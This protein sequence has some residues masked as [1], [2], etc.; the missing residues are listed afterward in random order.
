MATE[1]KSSIVMD[2]AQII[3]KSNIIVLA[4]Y[5]GVSTPQL[6]ALRRRLKGVNSEIKIVK[7][8]LARLAAKNSGKEELAK[9]LVGPTAITFGYGDV[10]APVKTLVSYQM[11]AEGFT[12]KGGLL[13]NKMYNKEQIVTLATLPSREVLLGHILGQM[14]AP[15]SMFIGAL[16]SP[17]RG[18]IGILQA[19]INQMEAK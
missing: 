3:V 18:F 2:L 17:M 10:T 15:I 11:E 6:T 12:I 13:G 8:T 9:S 14:N 1:S 5:R 7:N 4:D 16:A 19:R